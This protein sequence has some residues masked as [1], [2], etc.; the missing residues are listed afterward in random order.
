MTN[1]TILPYRFKTFEELKQWFKASTHHDFNELEEEE[2]EFIIKDDDGSGI[3]K[4]LRVEI[5]ASK[6]E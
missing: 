1:R 5:T 4:M 2:L 3:Y 6:I